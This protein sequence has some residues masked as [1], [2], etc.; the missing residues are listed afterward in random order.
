MKK[1]ILG[2]LIA[3]AVVLG[4]YPL[5]KPLAKRNKWFII[6][7]N[8]AQDTMRRFG[9]S[10]VQ[11]GQ[12]AVIRYPEETLPAE[13]QK[14]RDIYSQYLTY[15][16]W[17]PSSVAGKRV[18]EL[19]P[20]YNIG[21][22][23]LFAADGAEM[24]V[25]IDKF[26]PLQT[27]EDFVRFYSRLRGSLSPSQQAS[28][29]R[30]MEIQPKITLHPEHAVYI[31]HKDLA[32]C[33][34]TM[35]TGSYDLIVSNA[36]MEEI[37]DPTPFLRAQ[38]ELLRPGGVMVH[39]IDLRDYGMFSKH[40]FHPLEFLTV[41]EWVYKRMVS[42]SGQPDRRMIDYYRNIGRSMGY[43]TDVYITRVLKSASDLPEPRR[44][45]RAGV[46]YQD[47][48]LKMVQEIRPRLLDQ[49]QAL[50]DTDL[51]AASIVFVGRK[52]GRSAQRVVIP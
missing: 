47:W 24:V 10:S 46:D 29:D 33:V 25:G 23:L 11:I 40:G 26:V 37:Y 45:L 17:N 38:D 42:G 36:V 49:F 28:F 48:Q 3:I 18:I 20:G 51:L 13:I 35:G 44:E 21:V 5:W 2:I 8:V 4:S 27:H 41:P 14:I 9:L 39:R 1:K 12:D 22:P 6:A 32:D 52:P 15:S 31:D 34:Q 50:P 7:T 16:Q 43:Q 30:A 19:G